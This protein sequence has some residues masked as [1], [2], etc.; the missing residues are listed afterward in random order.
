MSDDQSKQ[1][2]I[3][4]MALFGIYAMLCV[5][6]LFVLVADRSTGNSNIE[7]LQLKMKVD[8]LER[9]VDLLV[10]VQERIT[11]LQKENDELKREL[12]ELKRK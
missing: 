11:S 3:V 6:V 1:H 7:Q 5:L 12:E 4:L 2:K 10:R 8:F 9:E